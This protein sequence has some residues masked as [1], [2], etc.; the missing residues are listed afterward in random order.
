MF[1]EETIEQRLKEHLSEAMA[2]NDISDWFVIASNGSMNYELDNENSDIDSK[3]LVVP[4]LRQ[5][6]DNKRNNYLHEM[7]D[8][9]EHVEVKDVNLYMKTILKQNINF[10][11]TLFAAGVIVNPKY[12]EEWDKL[13]YYREEIARYDQERAVNSMLG[14]M[15]QKR[16]QMIT[17]SPSRQESIDKIGYDAK[18]FHHLFRVFKVLDDYID[19]KSYEDCLASYDDIQYDALMWAKNGEYQA[20]EALNHADYLIENAEKMV[21]FYTHYEVDM[22]EIRE[23]KLHKNLIIKDF[24]DDIV[25]D[26]IEKCLCENYVE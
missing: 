7:S 19:G 13:V 1:D 9:G 17:P 10:V 22:F 16:K 18:S 14:M 8:N 20:D 3:L 11:E 24:I 5:L 23:R 21:D 2:N 25:Y 6:I 12:Q 4:S 26:I 15:K